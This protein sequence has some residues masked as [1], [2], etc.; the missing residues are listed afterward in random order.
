MIWMMRTW[1]TPAAFAIS[2]CVSPDSL[3]FT[4]AWRRSVF[5]FLSSPCRGVDA[6]KICLRHGPESSF[7]CGHGQESYH[8]TSTMR[9]SMV[10]LTRLTRAHDG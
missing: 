9:A 7:G 8:A 1:E 6:T 4:I 5:R 3:A 2:R 10:P